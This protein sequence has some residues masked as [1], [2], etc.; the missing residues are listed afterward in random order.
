MLRYNGVDSDPVNWSWL[1]DK[2]RFGFEAV[3]SPGRL[4]APLVRLG[5]GL[6]E[7]RWNVA[8]DAAASAI[9]DAAAGRGPS[10]VAVIGGA[11]L[12][13]ER[14]TPGPVSPRV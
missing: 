7:A 4:T 11:N 8:M 9:R 5:G 6:T 13:N 12:T 1:C 10:G 14:P 2:G 3:S